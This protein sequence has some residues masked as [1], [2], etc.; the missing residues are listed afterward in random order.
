MRIRVSRRALRQ[1]LRWAMA[2]TVG[3]AV[4]AGF[5]CVG[6]AVTPRTADGRPIL[7]SP[8]VRAAGEYRA[9]VVEWVGRF[10][11]IDQALTSLLAGGTDLYEQNAQ[12][13]TAIDQA[14]L[15]AQDIELT[16]V[17]AALADLR[18]TASRVSLQYLGAAQAAAALVNAPTPENRQAA[19]QVLA[20][21]Q[22][23]FGALRQSRWLTTTGSQP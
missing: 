17:P 3:L 19:Q 11:Q 23:D 22:Q 5:F 7:Y 12:A 13:G 15:L 18:Q 14:T 21:A 16:A 4:T 8:A 2:L 20:V 1:L 6:R 10:E 9:R